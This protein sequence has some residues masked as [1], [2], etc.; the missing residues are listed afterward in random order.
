MVYM[1]SYDLNAPSSN[2]EAVE[3]SIKSLGSW[4]KYLTTTFLVKSSLSIK[5]VQKL[6]AANLDSNDRMIICKVEKPVD[7]YLN[8]EQW[9]WINTNL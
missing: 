8:Q 1:I 3:K 4:C 7:G 6:C 2:R 5:D 9:D